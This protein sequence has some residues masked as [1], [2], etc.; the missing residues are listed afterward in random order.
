[1]ARRRFWSLLSSMTIVG[2]LLASVP[3]LDAPPAAADVATARIA[4]ADRYATAAAMA[5]AKFPN[6]TPTALV[7]SGATFADALAGAY[8]AGLNTQQ[9]PTQSTILLTAPGTL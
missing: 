3:L 7:A 2:A 5:R 8:F 4:G 6:G 9:C 1:M